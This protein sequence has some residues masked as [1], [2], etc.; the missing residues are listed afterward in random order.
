MSRSSPRNSVALVA[1]EFSRTLPLGISFTHDGKKE[2]RVY[3]L[4]SHDGRQ[5]FL[6]Y[7]TWCLEENI[8]F[9][10]GPVE[11]KTGN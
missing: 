6:R 4:N 3:D 11:V 7:I 1:K 9:V 2:V 10:G 5:A 8:T